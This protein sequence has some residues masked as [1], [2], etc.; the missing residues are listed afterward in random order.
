MEGVGFDGE[1]VELGDFMLRFGGLEEGEMEIVR[2]KL[3]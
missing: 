2:K 1:R 3:L